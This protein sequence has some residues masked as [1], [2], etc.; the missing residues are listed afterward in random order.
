MLERCLL[1]VIFRRRCVFL[2]SLHEYSGSATQ[3]NISLKR[4]FV[5]AAHLMHW[6]FCIIIKALARDNQYVVDFINGTNHPTSSSHDTSPIPGRYRVKSHSLEKGA[7]FN[8]KFPQYSFAD[9]LSHFHGSRRLGQILDNM[10]AQAA[11]VPQALTG[12]LSARSVVATSTYVSQARVSIPI[13]TFLQMLA[14]LLQHQCIEE[15]HLYVYFNV[16]FDADF[17]KNPKAEAGDTVLVAESGLPDHTDTAR[18]D[19]G[20][21]EQSEGAGHP[22]LDASEEQPPAE[23]KKSGMS[24]EDVRRVIGVSTVAEHEA[25]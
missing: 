20:S 15:L 25:A 14:W 3:L 8:Q 6:N 21:D 13:G 19:E 22:H 18:S 12:L 9:V 17:S 1:L 23:M 24:L 16:P 11:Q 2:L 7:L 4:I 5:L 10:A